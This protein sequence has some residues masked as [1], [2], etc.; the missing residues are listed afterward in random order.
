MEE[1]LRLGRA[2]QLGGLPQGDG[3]RVKEALADQVAQP[4]RARVDHDQAGVGVGQV[5]V[6]QDEVDRD[7][8]QHAGEQVDGDRQVLQQPAAFEL[9]AAHGV[10]HHHHK[11]GGDH[12]VE[13]GHHKGVH[14]PL[15]EL[16]HRVGVEQDVDVV[17]E[18][19]VLGEKGAEVDPRIGG[20]AG[21][22]QPQDGHQPHH[23]QPDQHQVPDRAVHAAP[24]TA[25]A[26]LLLGVHG[27]CLRHEKAASFLLMNRKHTTVNTAQTMN[28]MMPITAAIL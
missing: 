8:G 27:L 17:L 16:R 4:G 5:E 2:V 25:H 24:D 9:A 13:A 22:Q 26:Q 19:I 15:G 7:H 21:D 1:G 18:G 10:S 23:R 12:A 28:T 20:Q 3:H 11:G 6:A 14:E